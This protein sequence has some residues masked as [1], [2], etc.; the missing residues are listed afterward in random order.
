[1]NKLFTSLDDSEKKYQVIY[2]DPPWRYNFAK[3]KND[4]IEHH[5][6]TMSIVDIVKMHVPSDDNAV[7]FLWAT[8]PKL[9]EAL[10]V[11]DAWGFTY[12]TNAIWDKKSIGIGYW[13]RGQHELLLV[14]V[15]GNFSPP[16]KY[17]RIGSVYVYKRSIHSKKPNGFR[18]LINEWY[19][20][21]NKLEMF[22]RECFD[23]WD[24]YGNQLSDTIQKELIK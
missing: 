1:M 5:Y 6:A 11:M 19:P 2:V 14:G 18:T 23:G 12:I 7:L 20:D 24:A 16:P 8:A 9:R 13:F 17:K 22:A 3:V 10:E 15:K 4:S 21:A